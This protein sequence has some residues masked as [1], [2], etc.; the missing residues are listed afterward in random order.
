MS[1]KHCSIGFISTRFKGNDGVSLETEKWLDILKRL[2]Y[3]CFFLG[4]D[5]DEKELDY[6]YLVPE[7]HFKHPD[8][9]SIQESAFTTSIRPESTTDQ[10]HQ[11]KNH[12]KKHLYTFVKHFGI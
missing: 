9:L 8:I 1:Q 3:R 7:A 6:S 12:L 10:I 4:G 5:C 11:L 2:D